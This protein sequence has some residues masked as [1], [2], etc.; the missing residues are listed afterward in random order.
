ML[1]RSLAWSCRDIRLA[2]AIETAVSFT[3]F[4]LTN[5]YW[6]HWNARDVSISV[7]QLRCALLAGPRNHMRRFESSIR[8]SQ[9]QTWSPCNCRC[10]RCQGRLSQSGDIANNDGLGFEHICMQWKLHFRSISKPFSHHNHVF[11]FDLNPR[12]QKLQQLRMEFLSLSNGY[13][14]KIQLQY[15]STVTETFIAVRTGE[16]SSLYNDLIDC[17]GSNIYDYG[18][19][20]KDI[21]DSLQM[22]AIK[23]KLGEL[24]K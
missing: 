22:C 7:F 1:E 5:F 19:K 20:C 3:H 6:S 18:A 13:W 9:V 12:S 2:S 17:N 21:R 10:R 11:T 16:C 8:W 15:R 4:H 24:S 14:I 23:N